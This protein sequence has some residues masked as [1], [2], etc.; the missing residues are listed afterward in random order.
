M[1]FPV[2]NPYQLYNPS[3]QQNARQ[4]GNTLIPIHNIQEVF[5]YPV[6]PGNSVSFKHETEPYIFIK[7]MGISQFDSPQIIKYKLV[8]EDISDSNS[9][10][11]NS[12]PNEE[13]T[14]NEVDLEP[15]LDDIKLIKEEIEKIKQR[16][17][18][19]T[20]L[21]PMKEGNDI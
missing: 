8:K 16:L 17:E 4:D 19:A 1:N 10:P 3:M 18:Y 14:L 6:A 9:M 21:L 5:N 12:T 15:I 11:S 2:Y 13:K 7:T 20:P